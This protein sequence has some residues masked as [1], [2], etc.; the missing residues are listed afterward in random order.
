VLERLQQY[1]PVAMQG[2][3]P[4]LWDRAE[5]FHV[6]DRYGNRWI[7]WSSG[8]LVANAGHGRRELIDAITAQAEKRGCSTT[9]ASPARSVPIWSSVSPDCCPSR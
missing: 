4:I 7:D 8:V 9:T 2:Q 5:G 1:E 6:A 3:P